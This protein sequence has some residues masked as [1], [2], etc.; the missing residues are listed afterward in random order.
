MHV[1]VGWCRGRHGRAHAPEL[2]RQNLE[3]YTEA[4]TRRLPLR[5]VGVALSNLELRERQVQL[6]EDDGELRG[7]MDAIRERYGFDS[8]RVG[9][10]S[11][12]T[13]RRDDPRTRA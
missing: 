7:A 2:L 8:V 5:L 9:T 10:A 6:F 1:G 3:L 11:R 4:R 12:R 13:F